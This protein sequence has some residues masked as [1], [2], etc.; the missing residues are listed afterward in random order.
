MRAGSNGITFPAST[1]QLAASPAS[2]PVDPVLLAIKARFTHKPAAHLAEILGCDI[3]TCERYFAGAREP[4]FPNTVTMLRHPVTS[5]AMVEEATKELP[6]DEY[7]KF[8]TEMGRAAL[9]AFV[10]GNNETGDV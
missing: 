8:W 5:V 7:A 4:S 1:R 6:P 2:R 3:S 9:R 10:R